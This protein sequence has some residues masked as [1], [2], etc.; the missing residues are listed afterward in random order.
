MLLVCIMLLM[1]TLD[2]KCP[3][4]IKSI[5]SYSWLCVWQSKEENK[6]L[7]NSYM[8]EEHNVTV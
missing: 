7:Q 6:V 5:L 3:K 8:K 2:R 1:N 4:S